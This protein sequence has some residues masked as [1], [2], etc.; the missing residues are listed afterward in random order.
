[1]T[2][3]VFWHDI[4]TPLLPLQ[5]QITQKH[6]HTHKKYVIA[7]QTIKQPTLRPCGTIL[8]STKWPVA[9][10][11][12]EWLKVQSRK[13]RS[14]NGRYWRQTIVNLYNRVV[15]CTSVRE[16]IHNT[17][18]AA[19]HEAHPVNVVLNRAEDQ[20]PLP[21]IQC[22]KLHSAKPPVYPL[23]GS[24]VKLCTTACASLVC[25]I[26]RY[27]NSE[28]RWEREGRGA[29]FW[30]ITLQ[31]S[32]QQ[33]ETIPFCMLHAITHPASGG[34]GGDDYP[35][36]RFSWESIAWPTFPFSY[37]LIS[38]K[39]VWSLEWQHT[40][41][42]I[43]VDSG[44]VVLVWEKLPSLP[45]SDLYVVPGGLG[46][47]LV[48]E[49]A[50]NSTRAEGGGLLNANVQGQGITGVEEEDQKTCCQVPPLS[51]HLGFLLNL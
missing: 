27:S 1:M 44:A 47:A 5:T 45:P 39:P 33:R 9:F 37:H 30:V 24:D 16:G 38:V 46:A 14:R 40:R 11:G 4:C 8:I 22:V 2:S 34:R 49:I 15:A 7:S 31:D 50:S 25:Q 13:K 10:S 48:G 20:N 41:S 18:D 42:V 51:F 19:N 21:E 43:P 36:S 35:G 29:T 6:T 23:A 17:M 28:D 26:C 3:V 12:G 32:R